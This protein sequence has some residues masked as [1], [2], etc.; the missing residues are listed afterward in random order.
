MNLGFRQLETFR[1]FARTQSVTETARLMRVSQP[2]VSQTLKELEAQFGFALFVRSNGRT[3]LTVEANNVLPE[4]ERL[5]AQ[6]ASLRGKAEELK[7]NRAGALSIASVPSFTARILPDAVKAFRAARSQVKI[8][9]EVYTATDVVRQIRQEY[10]D[11]GFAFMPLDE[12]GVSVQPLLRMPMVCLVPA[13]HPLA[14][15]KVV[16][17]ND[18]AEE[19]IIVHRAETTPGFVLRESLRGEVENFQILTTNQS[20]TALHMVQSGIGIAFAHPLVLPYDPLG[21]AVAIPYERTVP[22]TFAMLYSRNRPVS[23]IVLQ[24]ETILRNAITNF[25]K[26][27]QKKGLECEILI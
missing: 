22:I 8:R 16:T 5:F 11:I 4:V 3:R 13:T 18:L 23:R 10:C 19:T 17:A 26:D 9:L 24:F 25:S 2:A 20:V 12:V 27:L 1:L 7:D 6:M 14:Q 15:R 21:Q